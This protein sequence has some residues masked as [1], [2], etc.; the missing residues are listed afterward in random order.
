MTLIYYNDL[1]YI[2]RYEI[3]K[4]LNNFISEYIPYIHFILIMEDIV[5]RINIM[6]IYYMIHTYVYL[7]IPLIILLIY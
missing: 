6:Y 2:K 5:C 4:L 3:S 7:C 1:Q